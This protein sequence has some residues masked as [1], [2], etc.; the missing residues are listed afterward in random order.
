MDRLKKRRDFLETAKGRRVNTALFAVQS[1]LRPHSPARTDN[2]APRTGFTVTKKS[3]NAVERNRMRRRLREAVR[4][5]G[6]ALGLPGH[7]Y[8]IVA[9][10]GVLDA[11]FKEICSEIANAFGRVNAPRATAPRKSH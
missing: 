10:K 11:S 8:V 9:R 7:D 5:S 2:A 1:R 6:P 3:G 4:L